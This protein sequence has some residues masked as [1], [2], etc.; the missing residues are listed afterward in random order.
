MPKTN[1]FR[2]SETQSDFL[3]LNRLFLEISRKWSRGRKRIYD[4][5]ATK[6]R[7]VCSNRKLN[8]KSTFNIKKSVD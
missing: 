3:K 4:L 2:W 1:W 7:Q 6:I 5:A 8:I